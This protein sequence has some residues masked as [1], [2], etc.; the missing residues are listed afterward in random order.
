MKFFNKKYINN[1]GFSLTEIMV[2]A[3]LLGMVSMISFSLVKN[4]KSTDNQAVHK[5]D[6]NL[7]MSQFGQWLL[8]QQGCSEFIN[9]TPTN[10]YTPIQ[11]NNYRG[12]GGNFTATPIAADYVINADHLEVE[13][14]DFR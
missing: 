5:T 3:G 12:Y 2:G 4:V 7:F 10:I 9:D 14:L 6:R 11:I 1:K 13:S 8:S